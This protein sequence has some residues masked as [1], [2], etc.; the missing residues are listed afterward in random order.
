VPTSQRRPEPPRLE[1][2][3]PARS[4]EQQARSEPAAAEQPAADR[5]PQVEPAAPERADRSTAQRA[6][7]PSAM[8]PAARPEGPGPE[9]QRLAGDL[10]TT[11]RQLLGAYETFL[12]SKDDADLEIT[13]A[14][15]QLHETLEALSE[16]AERL[17]NQFLAGGPIA[18]LRKRQPGDRLRVQQRFRELARTA[19]RVERL[20]A[21]TQPSPE[22]RQ[23]WT[24]TRRLWRRVGEIVAG[25]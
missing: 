24:E 7:E 9:L 12:A 22:V 18:R 11:S 2:E 14:D 17:H 6:A 3:V 15:E 20:M 23:S 4:A 21:E 25:I 16:A 8:P 19:E 13:D 1:T 10:E 5:A